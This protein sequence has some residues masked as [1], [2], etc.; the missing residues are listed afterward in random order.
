MMLLVCNIPSVM[1]NGFSSLSNCQ[2]E[3]ILFLFKNMI[4]CSRRS[5][6][7]AFSQALT[8]VG[9]E[10]QL[11]G[12]KDRQR[13]LC[14]ADFH[15][16]SFLQRYGNPRFNFLSGFPRPRLGQTSKCI[17]LHSFFGFRISEG[18]KENEKGKFPS[19]TERISGFTSDLNKPFIHAQTNARTTFAVCLRADLPWASLRS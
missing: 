4:F 19:S 12:A 15:S 2:S 11:L 10:G 6:D 5:K 17:P 18:T 3:A 16:G 14:K 8:A 7:A 1:V 9:R 13:F